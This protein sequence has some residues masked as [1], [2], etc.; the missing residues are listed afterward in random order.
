M[1]AYQQS[2][3]AL[4][5]MALARAGW[6]LDEDEWA[7]LIEFLERE[8]LVTATRGGD[9]VLCRDLSQ[10]SLQRLLERSPWPLPALTSLPESLPDNLRAPWYPRLLHALQ[11]LEQARAQQLGASLADWLGG[12]TPEG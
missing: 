9:W 3:R 11:A 12:E 2:G 4:S 1:F 7:P 5:R 6:A 8:R 10:I